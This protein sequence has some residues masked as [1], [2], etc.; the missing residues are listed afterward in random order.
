MYELS[1][2]LGWDLNVLNL[3]ECLKEDISTGKIDGFQV[4]PWT[5]E[6]LPYQAANNRSEILGHPER[7]HN[8]A[9]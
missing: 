5:Q 2:V 4:D 7:S 8:V 6:T 1:Q 9:I 3:L